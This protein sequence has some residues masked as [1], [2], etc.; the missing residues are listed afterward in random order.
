MEVAID[1]RQ[2]EIFEIIFAPVDFG[3]DMLDVEDRERRIILVKRAIFAAVSSAL[4]DVGSYRP[5][6][7]LRLLPDKLPCLTLQDG[8]EFVGADIPFV[9]RLF[10]LGELAFRRLLC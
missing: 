7:L 3:D 9:L 8:D 6:H 10:V 2:G 1:A 4:A 5:I